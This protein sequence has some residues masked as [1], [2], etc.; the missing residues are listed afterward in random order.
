MPVTADRPVVILT[1]QPTQAG[2]VEAGLTEAGY[3]VAFLPLTDFALPE[4][5][6]ELRAVVRRVEPVGQLDPAPAWLVLT[7]PNTV[8]ALVC[9]GWDGRVA[10]GLR[11]AVTG[12]GTARVLA[13]AGCTEIPWMPEGD[14]SAAGILAQFPS[15][16]EASG[17]GVLLPQSALAT[18]EVARGLIERGWDVNR[19]EAYRTVPYPA[20]AGRRL[21]RGETVGAAAG[22]PA[23][24]GTAA[25]TGAWPTIVTPEDLEGADVVLTSPSAVRELVRR[26]GVIVPA[27]TR[28]FAIG[29]PT[30][31]A[32][33][34]VGLVLTGTAPAPDAAGL[35]A[36]L[37]AP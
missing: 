28:F 5:L 32:A 23:G 17:R 14:A 24:T 2:A 29:Q 1:R 15:P 9:A 18:D 13:A 3:R 31:R 30:A 27:G 19:I 21:L 36:A 11:V 37:T 6:A 8:R 35:L 7:S 4:N 26:S 34:S 25:E 20:A 22:T 16:A 33:D 10:A 12:P